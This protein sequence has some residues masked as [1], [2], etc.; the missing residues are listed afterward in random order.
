ME[1]YWKGGEQ[2]FEKAA[3][4]DLAQGIIQLVAERFSALRGD[5]T[6]PSLP[7]LHAID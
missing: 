2:A 1:V 5:D 7:R 3:K 6:Q 4:T